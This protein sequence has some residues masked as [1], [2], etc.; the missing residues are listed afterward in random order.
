[1]IRKTYGCGLEAALSLIGGKWKLLILYNLTG[2]EPR[3]FGEL[4]RAIGH[5]SE[6]M[7]TQELKELELD[8]VVNRRDY[9]EVPPRVE[10][11]ITP[12]GESL[13]TAL[14]PLCEWGSK[15]MKKIGNLPTQVLPD[16]ENEPVV[17]SNAK[18]KA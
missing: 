4:R 15:H 17:C 7:L 16:D 13:M 10:Y 8:G 12:F 9:Q 2:G 11:T 3:R 18:V 14:T 1:M 5:I 6:K